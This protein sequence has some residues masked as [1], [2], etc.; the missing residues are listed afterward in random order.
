MKPGETAVIHA[1]VRSSRQAYAGVSCYLEVDDKKLCSA[2][3]FFAFVPHEKFAPGYRD[4]VLERF[5]KPTAA[6]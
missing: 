2:E 4:K 1:E 3:L 5:L 6:G